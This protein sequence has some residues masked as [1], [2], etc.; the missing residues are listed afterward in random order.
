M[1][2]KE[3]E[4]QSGMT[5]ANI[6]FYEA[7]GMLYPARNANG[8][9]NYSEEDLATLRKIRLLR[10][11]HIGLDEIK[12]I[13]SGQRR[14]PE[15]LALHE[16]SLQG[17]KENLALCREIC[18][19]MCADQAEYLSFD[20]E[21]YLDLL[22]SQPALC[23]CPDASS[24]EL[25]K[26]E[27]PRVTAPWQRFFA[28]SLD[29]GIYSLIW[30]SFLSLALH[31]NVCAFGAEAF[32]FGI[33]GILAQIA[34]LLAAEPLMLAL[35]GTTPG[36]LVFGFSVM[37]GDGSRL[38]W[39]EAFA[40]TWRVLG[41]GCGFLLPVYSLLRGYKSFQ[42][43][44]AGQMLEWEEDSLLIQRKRPLAAK[45]VVFGAQSA[46]LSAAGF[47]VWQ[48]GSLPV[49]RGELTVARFCSNYNAMQ[50]FYGISRP[51]N[52]PDTYIYNYMAYPM[53]L[54]DEG[55]WQE[56]PGVSQSFAGNLSLLPELVFAREDGRL[57]GVSFSLSFICAQKDY[58]LFQTPPV[59]IY[60][61]IREQADQYS[62]FTFT[63]AG[64]RVRCSVESSGY[65][66]AEGGLCFLRN[67][68][69]MPG[70]LWSFLWRGGRD[71]NENGHFCKIHP[72]VS[73]CHFL[74][75]CLSFIILIVKH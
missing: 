66:P 42:A 74:F 7:E 15:V 25:R 40:R 13:I 70:F 23:E 21:K 29:F 71:F 44:S 46:D 45:A 35:T 47:F 75:R 2:I 53:L 57:T 48:A 24:R 56:Y 22:Q 38:S 30:D 20:P 49:N 73:V 58:S 65:E 3:M 18:R 67:T 68:G 6:R 41:R 31:V 1:T 54:D 4:N 11:L 34:L 27:L 55:R 14:L 61:R 16:R 10:C 28:R 51:V 9:R 39:R 50:E 63:T 36:K 72:N 69:R 43:C 26:D 52:V 33:L 17:E 19:K 8:Y 32:I 64:V 62:D 37:A 12:E 5:R 59:E 60:D